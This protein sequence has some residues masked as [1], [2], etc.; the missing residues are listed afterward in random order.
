MEAS[1]NVVVKLE[2]RRMLPEQTRNFL[3]LPDPSRLGD[4]MNRLGLYF[5]NLLD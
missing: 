3:S 5:L 4:L 2:L 1:R